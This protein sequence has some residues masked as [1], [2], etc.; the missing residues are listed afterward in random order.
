M[1]ISAW[2]PAKEIRMALSG[3]DNVAVFACTV[4]ANLNGTGGRRGLRVMK[5]LLKQWGKRVVLA[6]TVNVCCSEEIMR[7]YIDIYLKPKLSYCDALV[8]LSCAGGVKSAFLCDPGVPVVAALDSLGSGVV[9]TSMSPLDVG[10]CQ[11]CDHCVLTY[12]KGVCPV[13]S[14]PAKKKYGPCKGA[15]ETEGPCVVDPDRNCVW[16]K[17]E[18]TADMDALAELAKM[19]KDKSLQRLSPPT[20]KTSPPMVRHFSGWFM[21]RIPGIDWIVDMVR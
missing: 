8:V 2:K 4:C 7:K 21:A 16:R 19:H 9:A 13:S 3:K 17:I 1:L 6:K 18:K 10:I 14:C 12:T 11:F 5:K 15:P 20:I